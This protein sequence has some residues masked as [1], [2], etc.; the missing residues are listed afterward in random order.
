VSLLLSQSDVTS[1]LEV[2]AALELLA[3]GLRAAPASPA[4]L[5]VRTDLPDPGTATCLMPGLL[6]GVP[7]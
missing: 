5:R 1:S 3:E 7:A 4:P 2:D 6:P